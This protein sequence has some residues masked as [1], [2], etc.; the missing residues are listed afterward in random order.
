MRQ[1]RGH[2]R[3]AVAQ[4]VVHDGDDRGGDQEAAE[5]AR[6]E[7]DVPPVEVAGD[8][9]ADPQGPERPDAGVTPEAPLLEVL[10]THLLIGDGAQLPFLS[11]HVDPPFP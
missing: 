3:D 10:L 4:A 9:G 1:R 8:D 11:G 2:L 5:P 6:A 7:P